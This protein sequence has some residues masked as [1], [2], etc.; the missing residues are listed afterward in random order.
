M[1]RRV[2][3]LS[4]TAALCVLT[5]PLFSLPVFA[6]TVDQRS[7]T[8]LVIGFKDYR[9]ASSLK[10]TLN[11][12]KLISERLTAAG[13]VV[14]TVL[15]APLTAL[16]KSVQTFLDAANGADIALVYYAGHAVQIDGENYIVPI[17]FDGTTTDIIGALYPVSKLLTGLNSTAKTR[18]V[19][20]DACRDNPF[21]AK[22]KERLGAR[23]DGQGLAAIQMPVVDGKSLPSG[24][25]G[26][27]VGY[28]TQ[29]QYLALD[30]IAENGRY[31]A[32]LGIA[33]TSPDEDFNT[34]LMRTTR[35]VVTQT[36]GRQ[37]PEHRT[38]LTGP[39]YLVSRPQPLACDLLAAEPDNDVSVKGVE[40]DEIDPVKAL[41]ACEADHKNN[42]AS[43]RLMH[44]LGRSL[45]R[46]GRLEEAAAMYRRSAD[47][48][49]DWA[50]LYLANAYM[51]GTGVK[52]SITDGIRWL[53]SAY[54][55]G[56]RQ[57]LVTYAELDLTDVFDGR[58]ERIKTLQAALRS[59][60]YLDVPDSGQLD[61]ETTSSIEE[62]K[63][64]LK[65][66]GK[67]ITFQVLDR[68]GIIEKLFP[69]KD[70]AQ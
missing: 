10:N 20:L 56:N 29:P 44:N 31:A 34:V 36:K 38:A 58:T 57:A 21:Q 63:S 39:L 55:Q 64:G 6:E 8:A 14:E 50:Q 4:V 41:P 53:R 49:H 5:V 67:S 51:E 12:A 70:L 61:D 33:L 37:Q 47:L 1:L 18:V 43:P 3:R 65:L 7:K 23:A 13:F 22:L 69:E 62:F 9:N 54:E 11:D 45:E 40:F 48:G 59:A 35:E 60:G 15:E 2:L 25:Q 46:A 68:L 16:T 30:G 27:V 19:L 42:P 32:A 28:A 17:D 26:L 24:T 66:D 52:P